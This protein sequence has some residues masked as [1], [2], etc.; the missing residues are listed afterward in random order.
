[1]LYGAMNFP[2]KPILSELAKIAHMGF[3]Y[4]ELAMDP[5]EA[6]YSRVLQLKKP[7][8]DALKCHDLKLV[9]H[10]PTFVYTADLAED[11]R[12]ASLKEM[13]GSLETAADLGAVKVV[14]HPSIISGMG[15]F[16]LETSKQN[17]ME[18]LGVIHDRAAELGIPLCLENMFPRYNSFFDAEDFKKVFQRFPGLKMTLDTG[19]ANI[20]DSEG[21]RVYQLIELFKDRIAHIHLSDNAGKRD[22][23]LPVGKGSIN[24]VRL[25]K[26]LKEIRYNDTVTLEIFSEDP[27]D[28]IESRKAFDLIWKRKQE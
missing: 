9:C 14:L 24:F 21:N 7:L 26:I 23:H 15:A 20:G 6:H 10:M 19:H 8:S 2:V 27:N 25:A 5:P 1:M 17:A 18:S 28:L 16:V 11:I 12:A 3:D 13:L 4:L 22:D